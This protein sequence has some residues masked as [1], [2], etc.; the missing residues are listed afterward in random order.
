MPSGRAWRSALGPVWPVAALLGC[1][2][3]AVMNSIPLAGGCERAIFFGPA[4]ASHVTWITPADEGDRTEL[5]RWCA[6][7]GPAL[8]AA[9][10]ARG[11]PASVEQFA[12]ISWNQN[13]GAGRL[14]QLVADLEAGVFTDGVPV[15]QFILL[16]QEAYREGSEIPGNP[17]ASAPVP[18]RI[19]EDD[20]EGVAR[21]D[22]VA[23]ARALGLG[24]FYAPSMRNGRE[25]PGEPRED[26]GNAIL[27]TLP[28][29]GFQVV[30]LPHERQR[31]AAIL[32]TVKVPG[33]PGT[34]SAIQLASLHL[35]VWPSILPALLDPS[36][37]NR[38]VGGFLTAAPD[39]GIPALVGADLNALSSTD[40]QVLLLRARWPSWEE[41]SPCRTRGRFC[42]DYL[43]TGDLAEWEASPYRVIEDDYGSDH[44]PILSVLTRRR[45]IA[46]R[47]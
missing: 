4:P 1:A 41:T 26:R 15:S 14:R 45:D 43:F 5:E 30:T 10:P 42:T 25:E 11:A 13:V 16:L 2:S 22:I 12:V 19:R 24:F 31:R 8:V 28:L 27:S 29:E 9:E 33:G 23:L 38:Q 39:S 34:P 18:P 47:R 40:P 46:E 21:G 3:T 37:R 6:T 35:D 32:A 17:P 7:V 44:L 36:R 20:L